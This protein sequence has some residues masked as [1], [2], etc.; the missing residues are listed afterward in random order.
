MHD[1]KLAFAF[2]ESQYLRDLTANMYRDIAVLCAER[3]NAAHSII[4]GDTTVRACNE[5]Y[6]NMLKETVTDYVN[7]L[8][9]SVYYLRS[10][11]TDLP[12]M[13]NAKPF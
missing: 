1:S 3:T 4:Q 11:A 12:Y 5:K 8:E 7:R 9:T 6:E 2:Q 10:E 13:D